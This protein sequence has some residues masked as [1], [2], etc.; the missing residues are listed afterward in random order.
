MPNGARRKLHERDGVPGGLQRARGWRAAAGQQRGEARSCAG[1]AA[2]AS[3]GQ[4]AGGAGVVGAA[5]AAKRTHLLAA[6]PAQL[7]PRMIGG[8]RRL[9]C[10]P[11][12]TPSR[13]Q[14]QASQ[15]LACPPHAPPLQLL[16]PSPPASAPHS[17]AVERPPPPSVASVV[18]EG[19]GPAK[20]CADAVSS[21]PPGPEMTTTCDSA[22][23]PSRP[24]RLRAP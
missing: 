2:P 14:A 15:L 5:L 6:P 16:S 24:S 18:A 11:E 20:R 3:R 17:A 19:R 4:R 13:P 23:L 8:H 1:V 12:T 22:L 7:D 10:A 21:R 9:V